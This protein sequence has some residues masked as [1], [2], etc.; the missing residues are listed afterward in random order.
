M[1]LI[2]LD[3]EYHV[4]INP[5]LFLI[6]CFV[7][8]RDDRKDPKLLLQEIG[9]IYFFYDLKSDFQFQTNKKERLK[10]VKKYVKMPPGWEVDDKLQE[11]IN[12]YN[13][14]SQTVS[15]RLLSNAYLSVDK[16]NDQLNLMDLN[17]RDKMGKPIWNI[18]QFADTTKLIPQL[19]ETLEQSELAYIKGQEKND[20]LRGNKIKTLY[21]DGFNKPSAT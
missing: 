12:T 1:K 9:F 2:E 15:G 4:I 10:D 14:L 21:E 5:E 11:C 19:M 16:I 8:L 7:E 3:S 13:Y 17:E 18:K 6:D 20:K